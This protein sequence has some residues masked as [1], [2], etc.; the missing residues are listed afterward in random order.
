MKATGLV[1]RPP[2]IPRDHLG[3]GWLAGP[4]SGPALLQ[5]ATQ[6]APE[7]FCTGPL[8]TLQPKVP[9]AFEDMGEGAMVEGRGSSSGKVHDLLTSNLMLLSPTVLPSLREP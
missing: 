1:T 5:G 4:G 8:P 9:L 6:E 3:A 2:R 7:P